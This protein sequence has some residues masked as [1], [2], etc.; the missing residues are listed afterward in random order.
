MGSWI[1]SPIGSL[2]GKGVFLAGAVAA[3]G[4]NASGT[5]KDGTGA[6]LSGV[7]V[8]V[9]DSATYKT[10]TGASGEF[11]IGSTAGILGGATRKAVGVRLEAGDFVVSGLGEGMVELSLVDGSGRNLWKG[12]AQSVQ[13]SARIT[14]PETRSRAVFLR[15]RQGNGVFHQAVNSTS[16]GMELSS[17]SFAS[18]AAAGNPVLLFKKSGFRDT[19]YAMSAQD[20]AKIAV[21]MKEEGSITTCPATKLAPVDKQEKTITVKGVSRKYILHVP[22]AYKGDSPVPLV[23]DF[24]P[25][26][27]SADNW[28]GSSPYKAETDPEG[29]VSVYPDGMDSPMKMGASYAKAWNVKGCCT[30]ADDTAFAR[31]LVAEIKKI[32]CIDP[33]RVY[34]TGFSMGGGMTHF[35]ACHLA[36][37]FAAAAPAAFDLLKENVDICKPVRPLAMIMFRGTNDGTVVYDGGNSAVVPGMAITF[38]GAKATFAKWA[39]LDKCTGSPSAE[40]ANGCSTYSNCAGGVQVTLCTKKG[41]GHEAGNA[42]VGWPLLKKYTLP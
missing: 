15:V 24:H 28:F 1:S 31:A 23:V 20:E 22:T 29:V 38:L 11:S 37:I 4:W 16:E 25:I 7:E 30:T 9:K 17:P 13:G 3:F 36:D 12:V 33:K 41:G 2:V 8:T 39:E 32:A 18:R 6:A 5:V 21:V 40:D 10:T 26:G 42:K 35:S 14:A 19:S 34:A 27:G